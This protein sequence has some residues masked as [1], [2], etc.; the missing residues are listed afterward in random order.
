MKY[1]EPA[2]LPPIEQRRTDYYAHLRQEV[3][4]AVPEG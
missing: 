1:V 4:E 2:W 3:I